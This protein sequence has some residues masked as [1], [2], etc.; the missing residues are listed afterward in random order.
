MGPTTNDDSIV[1][2][3]IYLW[4]GLWALPTDTQSLLRL[5]VKMNILG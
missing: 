2:I 4:A 5:F 3:I 1:I